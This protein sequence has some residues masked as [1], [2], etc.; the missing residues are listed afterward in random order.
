MNLRWQVQVFKMVRSCLLDRTLC[1]QNSWEWS[2]ACP[3]PVDPCVGGIWGAAGLILH[4]QM[5]FA[6]IQLFPYPGSDVGRLGGP[7]SSPMLALSCP[8]PLSPGSCLRPPSRHPGCELSLSLFPLMGKWPFPR[9]L[10]PGPRGTH[11]FWSSAWP[12]I[13]LGKGK[14]SWTA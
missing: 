11:P 9:H 12:S 5:D 3:G 2:W 6:L 7:L 14:E 4:W 8:F 10:L 13:S 1:S